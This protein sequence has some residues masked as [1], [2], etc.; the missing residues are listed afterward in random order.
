MAVG[1]KRSISRKLAYPDDLPLP[2]STA[3][4][5]AVQG[6]NHQHPARLF[7]KCDHDDD[8]ASVGVRQKTDRTVC[9][10]FIRPWIGDQAVSGLKAVDDER[11]VSIVFR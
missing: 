3:G 2:A 11:L 1:R 9:R 10:R 8:L 7:E 6:F 4:Q 5:E